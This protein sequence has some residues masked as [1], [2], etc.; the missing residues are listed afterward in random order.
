MDCTNPWD[1]PGQNPGVGSCSLLQGIFPIHGSNPGLPHCRWIRYQLSHL[2]SPCISYISFNHLFL[3]HLSI[4]GRSIHQS[5]HFFL[6]VI[7]VLSTCLHL[8]LYLLTCM[9]QSSIHM[10]SVCYLSLSLYLP[11]TYVS[12]SLT[13][14]PAYPPS[15]CPHITPSIYHLSAY[16]SCLSVYLSVCLP[17]IFL[18]LC[19]V[20]GKVESLG[21][22]IG[23]L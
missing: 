16:Y 7:C 5:S 23:L 9:Y 13:R 11:T 10:S 22:C 19:P 6:S 2:G 20:T 3:I 4:T 15:V 1:S 14:P 8:S 18:S 12:Y 21:S 17:I